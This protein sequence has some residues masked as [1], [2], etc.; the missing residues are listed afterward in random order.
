[1]SCN[2]MQCNVVRWNAMQCNAINCP[3][4]HWTA[5]KWAAQ[6]RMVRQ[7]TAQHCSSCNTA[8]LKLLKNKNKFSNKRSLAQLLCLTDC[9]NTV[10][11][12]N[13]FSYIQRLVSYLYTSICIL[14]WGGLIKPTSHFLFL[15]DIFV[16]DKLGLTSVHCVQGCS[17]KW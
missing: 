9:C 12:H 6:K 17:C 4:L 8:N 2:A 13:W 3:L 14:I 16:Y 7:Y 1:M 5:L 15:R 11:N 10:V